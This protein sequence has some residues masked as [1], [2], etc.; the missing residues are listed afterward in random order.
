M[1]VEQPVLQHEDGRQRCAS[2]SAGAAVLKVGT[3]HSQIMTELKLEFTQR[4]FTTHAEH[5]R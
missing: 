2:A 4:I 3:D 1:F 5:V